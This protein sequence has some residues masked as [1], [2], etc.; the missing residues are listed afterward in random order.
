MAEDGGGDDSGDGGARGVSK[1]GGRYGEGGEGGEVMGRRGRVR[2]VVGRGYRS[3]CVV[4]TATGG[5]AC[6]G[7][8]ARVGLKTTLFSTDARASRQSNWWDKPV[9]AFGHIVMCSGSAAQRGARAASSDSSVGRRDH[10]TQYVTLGYTRIL[11]S[12]V[13]RKM[14]NVCRNMVAF[15]DV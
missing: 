9:K 1:E 3:R 13:S 5:L 12:I 7:R 11:N 6:D 2:V 15:P 14:E 4:D 10:V 8:R